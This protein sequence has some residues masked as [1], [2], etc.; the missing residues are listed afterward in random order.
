MAS[1]KEQTAAMEKYRPHCR[2]RT[3][4]QNTSSFWP[5]YRLPPELSPDFAD[6]ENVL[7]SRHL[8]YLLFSLL[9]LVHL[10]LHFE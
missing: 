4:I 1:R 2:Q 7:H 10:S 8:H 5:P 9:S 3:G 6:L